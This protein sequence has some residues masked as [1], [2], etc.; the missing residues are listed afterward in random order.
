LEKAIEI[1]VA[2]LDGTGLQQLTRNAG[3][4]LHP[5]WS[6]NGERI[7]FVSD[8]RSPVEI[9]VMRADGETPTNLTDD[10][11]GDLTPDRQ[12]LERG[13]ALEKQA[14]QSPWGGYTGNTEAGRAGK[15][16]EQLLPFTASPL[17]TALADGPARTG[18]TGR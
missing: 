18:C 9:H 7:A 16:L 11:A 10:P 8:R 3:R 15:D 17:R 6:P 2:D 12:P 14:K 4:E 13:A 1:F 5:D